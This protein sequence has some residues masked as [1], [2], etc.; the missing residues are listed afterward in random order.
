MMRHEISLSIDVFAYYWRSISRGEK[1]GR[2]GYGQK[3]LRG[4]LRAGAHDVAD[5]TRA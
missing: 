3:S 4:A 1:H 2:P 5:A